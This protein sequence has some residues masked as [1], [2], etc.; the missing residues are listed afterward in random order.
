MK[1]KIVITYLIL[2]F[3]LFT[4][5]KK[6]LDLPAKNQRAVITVTDVKSLLASQLRGV[7]TPKIKPLYGQIIPACPTPATVMFGAYSDDIDFENALPT[8]LG[9]TSTNLIKTTESSYADILLWNQQ[10]TSTMLWSHHYD[11]VGFLNSLIDQLG[12]IKDVSNTDQDQLLGE[13]Y[14]NRA[15]SLFKLLQYYGIYN[16]ADMG[17]PIYL[18]TGEGV[19]GIKPK[20]ETHVNSYKIILE[21]LNKALEMV[22]RTSPAVGFNALY[23]KRFINHLLAQV[24]WY[25]AESPAKEASDYANV[26]TYSLAALE[27]VDAL[28][29][30]TAAARI[31]AYGGK[32]PNYPVIVQQ[33]SFSNADVLSLY[34]SGYQ[35]IGFGPM[36]I[37][38][39]ADF[40]ALFTSTD[41]RVANYFSAAGA[42]GKT[43]SAVWPSDGTTSGSDKSGQT[44]MFKP[45]EAYLMLMEAQYR[46]GAEGDALITLNKFRAFRNAGNFTGL[47]GAA[48]LTEIIN[49]RRRELFGDTDKRWLDLK[50]YA[51]KTITRNIKFFNKQYNITVPPNDYRYALPIPLVEIQQN[52]NMVPNPGW[53]LIEY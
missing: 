32:D 11:I 8:Y 9:L 28:I 15:Y 18:H 49:E 27:A 2:I 23:N 29:P 47:S 1:H 46:L 25:K 17:I 40:A 14:T 48:L 26:K 20:R 7:I 24:Y 38:L 37:P 50:R 21:D 43:L 33:N 30:T 35:Y 22:N 3:G 51:N 53:T 19:L 44:V 5:C 31:N 16:N 13:M 10:A 52:N 4:G 39:N 34:G 12:T 36:N 45:E 6:F 41:I 42:A